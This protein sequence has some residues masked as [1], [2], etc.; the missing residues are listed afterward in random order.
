MQLSSGKNSLFVNFREWSRQV[1]HC[2]SAI[3]IEK[4]G[5]KPN[6]SKKVQK[7]MGSRLRRAELEHIICWKSWARITGKNQKSRSHRNIFLRSDLFNVTTGK[8]GCQKFWKN[9]KS[10]REN[11]LTTA[12]GFRNISIQN[13]KSKIANLLLVLKKSNFWRSC[14]KKYKQFCEIDCH[15][16]NQTT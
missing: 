5:F 6:C 1:E 16:L 13:P 11:N 3:W 10:I 14:P 8:L 7:T 9:D 12:V 2:I 4:S 15:L